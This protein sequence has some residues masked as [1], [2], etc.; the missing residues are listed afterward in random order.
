MLI[1]SAD[2]GTIIVIGDNL[3]QEW[4]TG[5]A[6]LDIF[7]RW[8]Q[9]NK[10]TA[11][12]AKMKHM[13]FARYVKT[14]EDGLPYPLTLQGSSVERVSTHKILCVTID[15]RL[16]FRD[17]IDATTAKVIGVFNRLRGLAGRVVH[18][19]GA[20]MR[21]YLGAAVPAVAYGVEIWSHQLDRKWTKTMLNTASRCCLTT[22]TGAFRSVSTEAAEVVA[23][24]PPLD[25]LL[26]EAARKAEYR[27]QGQVTIR[28][29]I[30]RGVK[31]RVLGRAL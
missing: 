19:P 20:L 31:K 7:A 11:A 1:I 14:V 22:V 18:S 12:P 29:R 5:Q 3:Y 2:D 10:L 25:L 26:T 15:D 28:V 23:G 30:L 8:A 21:I 13:L 4:V 24:V 9:E 27:K 6:H 17:H 16:T